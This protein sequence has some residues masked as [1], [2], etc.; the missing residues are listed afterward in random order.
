MT[1]PPELFTIVAFSLDLEKDVKDAGAKFE[2]L[3]PGMYEV[4]AGEFT[5]TAEVKVGQT[6]KVEL[7]KK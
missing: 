6:T 5:A 3:G 4:R 7:K 2:K 1:I